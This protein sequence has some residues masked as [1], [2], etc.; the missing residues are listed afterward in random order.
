[1]VSMTSCL[2]IERDL[3]T[4]RGNAG[5]LVAKQQD[6]MISRFIAM[7]LIYGNSALNYCR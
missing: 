1:M 2:T 5:I 6:H 3:T 7:L 4:A